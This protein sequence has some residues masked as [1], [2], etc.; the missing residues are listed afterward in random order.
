VFP[1]AARADEPAPARADLP[2]P[3]SRLIPG[4]GRGGS[5]GEAPVYESRDGGRT[6]PTTEPAGRAT[7]GTGIV[8]VTPREV[9]TP[10]GG[11][12]EFKVRF[13]VTGDA[14]RAY[15]V[16]AVFLDATTGQ[17]IRAARA[18]YADAST[19]ALYLLL[20][21]VAH[22]GGT[23]E[24]EALL[25]LP[26][27]TMAPVPA[28]QERRVDARVQLFRRSQ[29]GGAD[30]SM[31]WRTVPF[32]VRGRG[33]GGAAAA[34]TPP[35]PAPVEPVPAAGGFPE[36]SAPEAGA[37]APAATSAAR[38]TPSTPRASATRIV[39]VTKNHNQPYPDGRLG[40]RLDVPYQVAGDAGR[41]FYVQAVFLDRA[42]GEGI[43]SVRPEFGDRTTGAVY[44]ITQPTRNDAADGQYRTALWV[45]YDAFPRPAPGT[46][47]GVEARVT[48]FRRDAGSGQDAAMDVSTVTFNVHGE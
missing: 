15:Y 31:D 34:P 12:T 23:S 1:S 9:V 48:L 36:P 4:G 25:Q 27:D 11:G 40:L 2:P 19:G 18:S 16:N 47:L 6:W 24:Y 37:P 22:R 26:A 41:S 21:P 29:T 28:G 32:V 35:A 14:G 38:E 3:Q 45:P 46:T 43:R 20:S 5:I 33:P 7:T 39:S 13:R 42:T 10:N 17:G 44:V 30:E 8:S